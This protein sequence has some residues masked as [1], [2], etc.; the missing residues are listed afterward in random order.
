MTERAAERLAAHGI[1]VIGAHHEAGPGQYELDLAALAPLALADALV[2]AKQVLRQEAAELGLQAT[3]MARPFDR[4]A[5]LRAAPAP[6]G[7]R[8]PCSTSGGK[9]TDDGRAFVAGQLTHAVGLTALAAPNGQLLQAAARRAGGARAVVWAHVPTGPP[10]SGSGRRSTASRRSSSG[11]PTRRA[12]PY[13]LVGGL[14][15]ADRPRAGR[16]ASTRA[17]ASTRT[18]AASTRR[19]PSPCS[20]EPLPRDLDDALDALLADDVLVDAFDSRLLSR[21]VDGRRAEAEEYRA[22]VTPW[23]IEP[24]PRRGL[25]PLG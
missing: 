24:L 20:Y 7:R 25:I 10:S 3:F 1:E 2:L 8:R 4:R 14:L 6:A 23:E 22:Q 12:N 18:W 19:R 17:A 13:L 21:L 9:L 5:R 11:W 16:R 15:A